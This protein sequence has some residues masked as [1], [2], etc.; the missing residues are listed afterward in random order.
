[1]LGYLLAEQYE[2]DVR[3]DAEA[4]TGPDAEYL[5]KIASTRN[6]RS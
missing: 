4:A 6:W 3:H 1:V 2:Y 5:R